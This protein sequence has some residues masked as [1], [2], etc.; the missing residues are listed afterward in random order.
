MHSYFESLG[1]PRCTYLSLFS[2]S[3]VFTR[4]FGRYVKSFRAGALEP[5]DCIHRS[6]YYWCK[7]NLT[8]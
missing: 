8:D 1:I 3:L 5:V 6:L 2:V 7:P 4:S